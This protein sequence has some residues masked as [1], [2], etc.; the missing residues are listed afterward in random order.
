MVG[1]VVFEDIN[2]DGIIDDENSDDPDAELE[3]LQRNSYY[4][5]G[6]EMNGLDYAKMN[7]RSRRVKYNSTSS[8]RT[9]KAER[10]ERYGL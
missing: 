3:V 2:D 6:M 4:S 1:M 8:E 10:M 5:F 9:A 7:E